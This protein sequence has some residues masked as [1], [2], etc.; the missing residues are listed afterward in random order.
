VGLKQIEIFYPGR[1]VDYHRQVV[2]V[3]H[4]QLAATVANFNRSGEKIP[5]VIGHPAA[6]DENYGF[7]TKLSIDSA[8]KVAA[9]AYEGVK[10]GFQ[11]LVNKTK[12]KISAKIRLPGNKAN[13]TEGIEF[14]HVGFFFGGDRVALEKL[15]TAQFSQGDK[16]SYIQITGANRMDMDEEEL[17][18]ERDKLAKQ[19]AEFARQQAEFIAETAEFAASKQVLPI[20]SDLVAKGA[21]APADQAGMVDVFTK[22][23]MVPT[24]QFSA[25]FAAPKA[26]GNAAVEFLAQA[27]GKKA[28]PLGKDPQGAAEF[29][30]PGDDDEDEDPSKVMDRKIQAM[31]AK[32]PGM[33]YG[34]AMDKCA[35]K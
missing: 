24:D 4:D 29:M 19:Q 16:V 35:P 18:A 33:S 22:L 2:P 17:Q 9:A 25:Q 14:D 8:G 13:S 10:A 23:A 11:S 1:H 28:V 26:G 27:I 34:A 7:I 5:L 3:T 15:P 20:V 6:N 12:P 30:D 21:I 31:M 32:N